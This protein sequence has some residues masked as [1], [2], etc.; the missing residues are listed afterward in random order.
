MDASTRITSF[1][2]NYHSTNDQKA[3]NDIL[4]HLKLMVL[5]FSSLPPSNVSPNK[6]EFILAREIFELEMQ[7]SLD[8]KNEKEFELAYMKVKQFYF[9]Y[10][11]YLII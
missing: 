7:N 3:K 8:N 5:T 10:K 4:R 1:I 11:Y 6:N 9:D 2:N